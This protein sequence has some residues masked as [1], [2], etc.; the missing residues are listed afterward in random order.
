MSYLLLSGRAAV[1]S[2]SFGVV[3]L[4]PFLHWVVVLPSLSP[5]E[6][7]NQDTHIIEF[8]SMIHFTPTPHQRMIKRRGKGQTNDGSVQF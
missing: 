5:K 7:P 2:S 6:K 3:L 4:S 8:N 1:I